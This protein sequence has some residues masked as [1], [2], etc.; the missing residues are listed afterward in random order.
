[1]IGWRG[2]VLWVLGGTVLGFVLGGPIGAYSLK[3]LPPELR[4][5]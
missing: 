3:I 2:T 5:V 1:M 4:L